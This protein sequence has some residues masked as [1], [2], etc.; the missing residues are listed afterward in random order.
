MN[1]KSYTVVKGDTL[2]SIANQYNTTV[3]LILAINRQITNPDLIII[4]QRINIPTDTVSEQKDKTFQESNSNYASKRIDTSIEKCPK[5]NKPENND[6]EE[7]EEIVFEPGSRTFYL[8]NKEQ[9]EEWLKDENVWLQLTNYLTQAKQTKNEHSISAAKE[10]LAKKLTPF[11]NGKGAS[12]LTEIVRLSGKK[13]RYIRSDKMK[14]HLRSYKLDADDKKNSLKPDK[15]DGKLN[16]KKLKENFSTISAQIEAKIK[17]ETGGS[18]LS[19]V[20]DNWEKYIDDINHSL[21]WSLN[22]GVPAEKISYDVSADAQLL[23]YYAGASAGISY[24]PLKGNIGVNAQIDASVALAEGR[25][26][27]AAYWPSKQGHLMKFSVTRNNKKIFYELGY[28]RSQISL[29]VTGFA[30]ASV[31]GSIAVGFTK[32]LKVCGSDK[33]KNEDDKDQEPLTA[34]GRLFAGVEA[35][36]QVTGSVEWD[37]PEKRR[38]SKPAWQAFIKI[39]GELSGAAGIGAHFEFK[40]VY[41]KGKFIFTAKAGVIVG[42]GGSGGLSGCVDAGSIVEFIMYVYHK[43]K[44]ANYTYL[45]FIE[46]DAFNAISKLIVQQFE[47]GIEIIDSYISDTVE[48]INAYWK[49]R[50]ASEDRALKLAKNIIARPEIIKFSSPEAKGAMLYV[51]T[52][53]FYFS[54]EET[55]EDAILILLSYVQTKREFDQVCKHLTL[56]GSKGDMNDGKD[57]INYILDFSQQNKFDKWLQQLPNDSQNLQNVPVKQHKRFLV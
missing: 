55:Q 5:L 12:K 18:I 36:G 50:T 11:V 3:N 48:A 2:V 9:S 43:L 7:T 33:D 21:S 49:S 34:S 17:N 53:T 30:G 29:E 32:D 31:Q 35:G 24:D 41:S 26:M 42:I 14:N 37:N 28:I 23:R 19:I 54:K 20:N 38:G 6:T 8:L 16:T 27:S 44:E 51:L 22:D 4:G 39:G 56:D 40:I 46:S 57:R 15:K 45:D 25:F 13:Y 1:N 47:E 10:E 52:E